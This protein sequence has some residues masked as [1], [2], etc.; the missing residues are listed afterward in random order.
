MRLAKE[1]NVP[2]Q[3]IQADLFASQDFIDSQRHAE[4]GFLAA[5]DGKEE[6]ICL[7]LTETRGGVGEQQYGRQDTENSHSPQVQRRQCREH[8]KYDPVI[9]EHDPFPNGKDLDHA[10]PIRGRRQDEKRHESQPPAVF[11]PAADQSCPEKKPD[12]HRK[13]Q[14]HQAIARIDLSAEVEMEQPTGKVKQRHGPAGEDQS[15]SPA[16]IVLGQTVMTRE[17]GGGTHEAEAASVA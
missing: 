16:L 17:S 14:P 11:Q 15:L 1:K 5:L 9:P 6:L 4:R 10:R 7:I 2:L 12:A 3:S 13:M 8:S